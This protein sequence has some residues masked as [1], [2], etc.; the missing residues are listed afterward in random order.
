MTDTRKR[1]GVNR[2]VPSLVRLAHQ[3]EKE[4]RYEEAEENYIEA[5]RL[6]PDNV[7]ALVGLGE[8]KRKKRRFEEAIS[9]YQRC[10]KVDKDNRFALPGLGGA[11]RGLGKVDRALEVWLHYLS[12]NPHDYKVMTRVADGFRKKR[13][14]EIAKGVRRGSNLYFCTF[15]D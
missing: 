3:M 13:D 6:D 7:Y 8:V 2:A 9:Y 15:R 1:T 4:G 12:L 14:F 10:L 5:L 11:Y